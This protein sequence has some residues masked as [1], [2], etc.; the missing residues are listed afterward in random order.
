MMTHNCVPVNHSSIN[1]LFGKV[2]YR[3][4]KDRQLNSSLQYLSQTSVLTFTFHLLLGRGLFPT[5]FPNKNQVRGYIQKFS[6]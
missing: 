2:Q 3:N 6:G 1:I 4:T 5:G